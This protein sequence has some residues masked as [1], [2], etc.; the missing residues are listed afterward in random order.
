VPTATEPA[1]AAVAAASA[2]AAKA[3]FIL[4]AFLIGANYAASSGEKV[5]L[6]LETLAQPGIGHCADVALGCV[7]R[8]RRGSAR[9]LPADDIV[10]PKNAEGS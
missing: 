10:K 3:D 9:H 7:E 2:A 1:E 5:I 6:A 4:T 8:K